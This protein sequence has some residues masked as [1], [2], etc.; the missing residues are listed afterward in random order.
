MENAKRSEVAHSPL[1]RKSLQLRD[2]MQPAHEK[3]VSQTIS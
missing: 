1:G 2:F 3:K